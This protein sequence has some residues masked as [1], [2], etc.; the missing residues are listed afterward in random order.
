MW[1]S[2]FNNGSGVEEGPWG[3]ED[4]DKFSKSEM[5][6]LQEQILKSE[7]DRFSSK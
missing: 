2:K 7:E 1:C 4:M 5:L 6:Q 3:Q